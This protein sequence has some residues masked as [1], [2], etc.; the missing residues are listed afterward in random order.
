VLVLTVQ[1]SFQV[2]MIHGYK[3]IL[4]HTAVLDV[5]GTGAIAFGS[6]IQTQIH[7]PLR[8]F[9]EHVEEQQHE[10][11]T[12]QVECVPTHLKDI[13]DWFDSVLCFSLK[14]VLK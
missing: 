2:F 3:S 14:F 11:C 5:A 8:L 10:I 12:W 9:C 7:N 6:F 4:V 13:K 1:I